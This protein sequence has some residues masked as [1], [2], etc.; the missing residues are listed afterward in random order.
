MN[1]ERVELVPKNMKLAGKDGLAGWIRTTWLPY[2]QRLPVELKDEFIAE[3]VN[4][5]VKTRPLDDT[6]NVHVGMVRL[7]VEATK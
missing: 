4:R 3:I 2:T 5:H 6:G 1:P 7:E